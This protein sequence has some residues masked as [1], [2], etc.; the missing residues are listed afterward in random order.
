MRAVWSFWSKPFQ[1][2]KGRIWRQPQHHLLAWGLSLRLAR[3]HFAETHLVTDTAGKQ[4]LVDLLGLKFDKVSTDLDQL[5]DADPGW[6]A[7]GKLMAY[8]L[9]DR[10]FIHI[11]S[12]VFLWRVLPAWLLA[13]P[14]FAQCPESHPLQ[15]TWCSPRH[16]ES[17]FERHNLSLP[18]EWQWA[19]SRNTTWF[20]EE[21]CGIVG[22]NNI[23]FIRHYAQTALRMVSDPAHRALW[24]ELPEKSGFTMLIEQ[25]LL[26]CCIDYH[27]IAPQSAHRGVNIRY[28]FPS[29]SEAYN[30]NTAATLGYT[31]LLGDTKTHP[32][33]MARLERRVAQLDPTFLRRC[34][35]VAQSMAAVAV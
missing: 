7:L 21:N 27:R 22:A 6:W 5:R 31:H 14:V 12:D 19:S 17:L 28:L 4:M 23:E 24:K 33:V 15:D 10:S 8:S 3:Q 18:V 16:I 35:R 26:A 11:D 1:A 20:R 30:P 32:G 29:W 34:Q 2:Y 13:A 9:Q 25:F